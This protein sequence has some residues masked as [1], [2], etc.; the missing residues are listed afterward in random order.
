[1]RKLVS[2]IILIAAVGL[3]WGYFTQRQSE[4]SVDYELAATV[5]LYF[6]TPDAL[7]L[8]VEQRVLTTEPA[9]MI[10]LAELLTGTANADLVNV[11]PPGTQLNGL[12]ISNGVAYVDFN[13]GLLNSNNRG[14]AN[15]LLT[16][17]AIVNT[18]TEFVGIEQVQILINGKEVETLYGHMDLSE[19]LPRFSDL[20][21]S[22]ETTAFNL[23]HR[24]L[25]L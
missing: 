13:E 25:Q 20:I 9:P 24:Q 6:A 8:E 10:A 12:A 16:V 2:A 1:M 4:P 19:P 15:E 11:I 22:P 18:L 14:S 5:A 21:K 3:S 23:K 17:A 7:G